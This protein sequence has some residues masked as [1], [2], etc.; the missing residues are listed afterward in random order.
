M[1]F[2]NHNKCIVNIIFSIH[3]DEY[4]INK[5]C[6]ITDKNNLFFVKKIIRIKEK[7]INR[8][9][10]EQKAERRIKKIS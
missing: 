7:Y 1:S 6:L 8:S 4:T 2:I 10:Y 3:N 9:Y 5:N